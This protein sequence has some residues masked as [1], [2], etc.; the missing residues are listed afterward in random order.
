MKITGICFTKNGMETARRI[1]TILQNFP[2][3]SETD[4]SWYMKGK[5]LSS[6]AEKTKD[7]AVKEELAAENRLQKE[8]IEKK[9]S[10]I[11]FRKW[12]A[13]LGEWT[14]RSFREAD[15]LLFISSTGIAVRS[16]APFLQDKFKD[17]AVIVVD[18]KGKFCISL[19]SGHVG[20][21]N[22]LTAR[23][24]EAM[25]SIPV[26]TTATDLNRKFAVDL[27]AKERALWI[28]SRSYAKEISAAILAGYQ[29]PF[30]TGY[31]T[32]GT[33]PPELFAVPFTQRSEAA[34]DM[35][36]C[37]PEAFEAALESRDFCEDEKRSC[38]REDGKIPGICIS[39]DYG[40]KPFERTLYLVPKVLS[41]GIGCK[42]NTPQALIEEAFQECM[43]KHQLFEEAVFAIA[44]IDL[45]KEEAG[46]WAFAE[47]HAFPFVT[48][49]AEELQE[50]PGEFTASAF[51]KKTT[52]VDN[53]CERA[54][55]LEAIRRSQ[56]L[57]S[58]GKQVAPCAS[59]AGQE[60]LL[61]YD[62]IGIEKN[63]IREEDIDQSHATPELIV[64]K[65]GHKGVTIAVAMS[66]WRVRF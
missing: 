44:S 37:D 48:Y 2:D 47:A 3:T 19:L 13:S 29:I 50:V 1:N 36:S 64:R 51:V 14:E 42:K 52:G 16:I 35:R 63:N 40:K 6:Q 8:H 7:Q 54:A 15:A 10:A 58:E 61:K 53:V 66:G 5:Y 39:A 31:E 46:L 34:I 62:S 41:V 33:Y 20:G 57:E 65:I 25:Q 27:F 24:A 17:P 38:L 21:A 22:A 32:Q 49:S 23:I 45:K 56:E 59:S 9:P 4:I 55:M 60:A 43:R 26:I 28:S 30:Y 12:G 18:E 11:A